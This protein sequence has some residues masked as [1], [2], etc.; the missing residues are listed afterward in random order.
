MVQENKNCNFK[1]NFQ[2]PLN[3][4][5]NVESFL[6]RSLKQNK[7]MKYMNVFAAESLTKKSL[8]EQRK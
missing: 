1:E 8:S 7:K 4:S 3:I 5:H 2:E 6:E